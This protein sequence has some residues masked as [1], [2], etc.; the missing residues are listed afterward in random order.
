GAIVSPA[1]PVT[2]PNRYPIA[3]TTTGVPFMPDANQNRPPRINQWSVGIQREITKNFVME[4]SYVANRAAWLSGPLGYL[5]QIPA[6][7]YAQFGLYPYPGTGPCSTGGGVCASSTSSNTTD[8]PWLPQPI[9]S[10][11]VFKPMSPREITILFPSPVSPAT[12]SLQSALYPFP[13]FGA[14]G[15]TGSATGDSRYDG[16]QMKATK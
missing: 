3:N 11:K 9:T 1:W 16:L 10:T 8:R 7:R 6:A 5:S 15:P 14:I 12:N 4:A 13:Q 2:D